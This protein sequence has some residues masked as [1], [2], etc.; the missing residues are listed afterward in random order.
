MIKILFR[1]RY[2]VFCV[3]PEGILSQDSENAPNLPDMLREQLG[4]SYIGTVHRL[5]RETSG[6]MVYSLDP[7]ITGKLTAALADKE[8]TVK[9]YRALLT[10]VPEQKSGE[11]RDLLYHDVR[12][13]KT[14]VVDRMRKGVREAVL[15]YD[16]VSVN[17]GKAL[18]SVKLL[19]GRT[20]QIRVQFASRGL[21]ICGDGKYGG[22]AGRLMLSAV[23]LSL[24]HPVTRERIEAGGRTVA[25]YEIG[26]EFTADA[27]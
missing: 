12:R 17:D 1:D 3:K 16:V 14:F 24:I 8:S 20:H 11:L 19:T 4:V 10:G 25:A 21:P 5:D 2:L 18:V 27:I 26:S 9:E 22:G 7:K 6:V 15:H 13:N 23:R